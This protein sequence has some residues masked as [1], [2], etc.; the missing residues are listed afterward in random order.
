MT[1]EQAMY[2]IEMIILHK[3]VFDDDLCE[4]VITVLEVI[5]DQEEIISQLQ[6]Q[7]DSLEDTVYSMMEI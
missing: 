4:A 3:E 1:K 7:V 2:G 6:D 5:A